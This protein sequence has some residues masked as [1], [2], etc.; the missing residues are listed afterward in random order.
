MMCVIVTISHCEYYSICAV[1]R[2]VSFSVHKIINVWWRIK[3]A[4]IGDV[5]WDK[6][7]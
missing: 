6:S 2:P 7:P 5:T 3:I 1:E 4:G